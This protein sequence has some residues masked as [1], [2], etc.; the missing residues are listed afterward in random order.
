MDRCT[1]TFSASAFGIAPNNATP[2]VPKPPDPVL[3]YARCT[4]Q[5]RSNAEHAS[6]VNEIVGGIGLGDA[7]VGCAFTGP[8]IPE[9]EG[10]VAG[11]ELLYSGV[12]F[13]AERYTIWQGENACGNQQ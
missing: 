7:V 5:V 2:A 13:A 9:C 11:I 1:T 12:N 8:F 4:S 10:A 6:H 3:N